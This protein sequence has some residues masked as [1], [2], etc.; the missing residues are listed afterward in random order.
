M[1]ND[2]R[3]PGG[4][5]L[6]K[7]CKGTVKIFITGGAIY[8]GTK[9]IK[10]NPALL[11]TFSIK[12][13]QALLP[14]S[15]PKSFGGGGFWAGF[16]TST[17]VN[18]LIVTAS[19]IRLERLMDISKD[20][21]KYASR[22]VAPYEIYAPKK[23]IAEPVLHPQQYRKFPLV[24]KDKLSP[25]TYRFVFALP[26]PQDILGLPTGQHVAIRAL[27]DG[28][29]V[30]RSYTPTSNNSDLGRIE[31]VIKVYPNGLLTNYLANLKLNDEVE[32][33]GPKG[34]M[35]YH[36]DLCKSLGMIAGGTGI[37]PMYQLI[38]AICEDPKDTT[39]V[40]LL[41]ANQTEADI[42]LREELDGWA[43]KFPQRFKVWYVLDKPSQDWQY[44]KGF[45]TKELIKERFP[46]ASLDSN[47][48]LCGPPGMIKAMTKNLVELGFDAPGTLSKATD[49]IFLF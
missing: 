45:I 29:V 28:K 22:S 25:N 6:A 40:S 19:I 47:V 8:A 14:K 30:S 49:Q 32:F 16:G 10:G 26:K 13:L 31:M 44:G 43:R 2:L 34:S 20:F 7:I 46:A 17:L 4:S 11:A 33:R 38:R 21:Q 48:H 27:I 37:T 42:L 5:K 18:A 35:K 15:M 3:K 9:Y 24:K 41:Y 36:R 23:K 39:Q 12:H 1:V